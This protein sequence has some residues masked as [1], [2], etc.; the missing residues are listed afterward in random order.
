M[1]KSINYFILLSVSLFSCN[2]KP[3]FE[4]ALDLSENNRSEL[5]KVITYFSERK[6]DSLQLKAA[7]FLIGNMPAHYSLS[8][9]MKLY[10]FGD[11]LNRNCPTIRDLIHSF[12]IH[13]VNMVD[14]NTSLL[15]DLRSLSAD[16][17]IRHINKSVEIWRKSPWYRSD[18]WSDFCEY[19]LPYPANSEIR[20][21]WL[22]YYQQKYK[23]Y[24]TSYLDTVSPDSVSLIHFCEF[25]NKELINNGK[26]ILNNQ[27]LNQYPPLLVDHI[28]AGTCDDYGARTIFIMRSL[29]MPV[30]FDF[31]P[32]W[33]GFTLTHSWNTLIGENDQIYPFMGFDETAAQWK[34]PKGFHCSKV[35]RRTYSIQKE[36]L[37]ASHLEKS[38]PDFLNSLNI[39][40]VT[41]QYIPVFDVK[42]KLQ[43]ENSDR[44]N[45]AY[46]CLF[47]TDWQVAHWGRIKGNHALF[48]DMGAKVLYMPAYYRGGVRFD[49]AGDLFYIDSLG[50]M[51]NY[52][53]KPGEKQQMVLNR[54][55]P[56]SVKTNMFIK[57]M[58]GGRFQGADN[59]LFK[60]AEDIY[61]I[62]ELP[63]MT[64]NTVTVNTNRAYRYVRYVGPP[65]SFTNVAEIEFY[66]QEDDSSE[67]RMLKGKII[68]TDNNPKVDSRGYDMKNVFDG[69]VLTFFNTTYDTPGWVGLDLGKPEKLSKIRYLPR[70]DDNNIRIGDTYELVYWQNGRWNSL[71]R[72]VA[73]SETLVYEDCPVGTLYLLHNH[74][75]GKEERIFTY[76]DGKQVWW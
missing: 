17:L 65:A 59:R 47:K 15:Y 63:E 32:Q 1:G 13:K 67:D 7:Y 27:L 33:S 45:V 60:N 25:L 5:E 39:K 51:H 43:A 38:L 37:A 41:N 20:Q 72:K 50:K 10:S 44:S 58:L 74:T 53:V 48:K 55:Y 66:S 9:P 24:L 11:S 62:P 75:R 56:S 52:S 69:N 28:K 3:Q 57:R 35:F 8:P 40:D 18:R 76:E 73:E 42:V 68:G 71:G 29:G 6:E 23:H 30:C 2:I 19:V 31:S 22:D 61:V 54:K 21:Y 26:M 36:S 46:L 14:I 49:Q 12:Y 64:F 70:N 34:I 4:Q 16:F